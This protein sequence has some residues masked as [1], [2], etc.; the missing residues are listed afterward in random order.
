MILE[1]SR[2][3]RAGGEE[4]GE[5]TTNRVLEMSRGRRAG[6]EERGEATT[7]P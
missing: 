6:G 5:A 4:R 1:M 2:G 3:R 7:N